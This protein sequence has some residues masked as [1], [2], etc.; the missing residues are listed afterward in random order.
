M[1]KGTRN[2]EVA[3][4]GNAS[5]VRSTTVPNRTKES[6]VVLKQEP[7]SFYSLGDP[8]LPGDAAILLD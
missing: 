8:H 4:R 2:A 6:K 7:R 1:I 3:M 5:K